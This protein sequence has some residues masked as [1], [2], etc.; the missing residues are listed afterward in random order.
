M[1]GAFDVDQPTGE[2]WD[3]ALEVLERAE[4]AVAIGGLNLYRVAGG[5]RADHRLH[6]EIRATA[7]PESLTRARAETDVAAGLSQLDE[8]R[9][10]KRFAALAAQH[11]VAV[12]YVTD[13][14][15][16]RTGLAAVAANGS[17]VWRDGF[18]PRT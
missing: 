14:D 8:L 17:L 16:G 10:D 1:R 9:S 2:R 12:E 7:T 4:S 18:E 3:L 15:T 6:V 5:P 13:Y 11:G